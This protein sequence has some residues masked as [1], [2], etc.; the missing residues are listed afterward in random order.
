MPNYGFVNTFYRGVTSTDI[1]NSVSYHSLK[2]VSESK[3]STQ[4]ELGGRLVEDR[5]GA[6]EKERERE[7]ERRERERERERER[8]GEWESEGARERER[9]RER[10]ERGREGEREAGGVGE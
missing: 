4:R 6:R 5:G 8:R 1:I 9:E 2:G 10:E 3:T 7:R